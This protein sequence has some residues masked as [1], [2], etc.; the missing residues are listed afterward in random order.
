MQDGSDG[1]QNVSRDYKRSMAM[2]HRNR[3]Y[4]KATLGVINSEAHST[5]NATSN[6]N[7]FA[8]FSNLTKPF[9]SYTVD[10]V[11]ATSEENFSKVDGSM[12]FCPKKSSKQK[13]YNNGLVTKDIL[14]RIYISFYGTNKYDIKGLTID[15]G[16]YYPVEFTIE[17]DTVKHFYSGNDKSYW[18]TEDVFNGAS[19][20]IITP[21]KMVNGQ[22]RLRVHQFFCG[23]V[24]VFTNKETKN[25]SMKEYVSSITDTIPSM[26][27]SLTVDNQDLYYSPDNP[28]SALA[29]FEV[30]QEMKVAFGY[31]V[32]GNGVIEWLPENTAY[33][34]SWTATDIEAKFTATDRFVYLN[35]KYYR[36]AYRESG[37]SLYD[38]A[39]DVLHDAGIDD[40]RQ[41]FIDPYLKK[42]IVHNPMPVTKHS[43][44]LQIIANAGRCALY[45][46]RQSRIHMQASFVP[47]MEA[48]A[49]NQANY[50]K[51]KNILNDKRKD[52]YA[53]SNNNFSTVDGTVLFMPKN[54]NYLYTGY[55]S[56]SIYRRMSPEGSLVNKLSFRLGNV[57]SVDRIEDNSGYWDGEI[58]KITIILEAAF[59]A[60]GLLIR[61]RNLAPQEF[62]ARTF[63]E[64]AIVTERTIQN[65][66]LEYATH[67]RFEL[68]DKM[69]I[70]ITKGYFDA[71][72]EIDNIV[73]GDITD[74]VLSRNDISTSPTAVR[75][76]KVK[77]ISIGRTTYKP[78][79]GNVEEL[80]SDKVVVSKENNTHI[81]YF[82]K[83]SYNLSA[84]VIDNPNVSVRIKNSSNYFAE[85]EFEGVNESTLIEYIVSGYEYVVEE[86][87]LTVNHNHNG[88]EILWDNPLVSTAEHA[89]DLE[90][91]IASYYLGD[92][93]YQISWRG[94]P[95]TDAND[96]FYLEL[97][98]RGMTT[99]RCY[100][101]ELTFNGAWSGKMK[102]RKVVL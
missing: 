65:Y 71:Q 57:E 67:E 38:L 34:K 59:V 96:L 21:L 100:Q 90:E 80:E 86:K 39:I 32:L 52:A 15:W 99:V 58:P 74:Y 83:A 16:E 13:F 62:V 102:A 6:Q 49:N 33:L 63:Y 14:G 17:N 19:Y 43:E 28:E 51:V 24:N 50:S 20:F 2:P 10:K 85:L 92:V 78:A 68:F 53:I 87:V 54:A 4:I 91:W 36:G 11:Y 81:V 64:G 7:K 42:T 70:E 9:D 95:R 75:Q 47:D 25:F 3:G 93:D 1:M 55:I 77:K 48:T 98:D 12:Y 5:V 18:K 44:A 79:K 61:F 30:G 69:E 73:I 31:D 27:M 41:Y 97:K 45:Q 60:Y 94:D 66:D 37:I 84:S 89:K 22:G 76:D 46:D 82:S 72:V 8:Y 23:I 101:N 56:K 88:E 40:E 26:N 29:Y 35:G